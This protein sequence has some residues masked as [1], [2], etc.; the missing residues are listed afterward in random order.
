[1]LWDEFIEK[2]VVAQKGK[3][4]VF[5]AAWI[6]C[7][8]L[9]LACKERGIKIEW[10]PKSVIY[11]GGGTK[12]FTFPDGWMDVLAESFG[13][14]Y[15]NSFREGYGTTETTASMT[16]C[17]AEGH[18]HPLPWGIQH[19]A[20]P[21]T[22]Q[23]LPRKGVQKGRLLTFDLLTDSFWS[24]TAGGDEVTVNW[25]GGCKC[26]RQGPYF[27]NDIQRFSDTRGGDDKITCSRTPQAFQR[28]E[29]FLAQ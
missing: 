18:L 3:T 12:G 4:V 13:S 23:P 20:D 19:V 5:F 16:C 26:G 7:Y 10:S 11:G 21:D 2:T 22:G 28:L 27:L 24:G 15:P 9:A 17:S 8:Q 1:M 29:E 6:Q 25:D 14:L